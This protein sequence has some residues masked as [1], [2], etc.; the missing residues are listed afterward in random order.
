MR[1]SPRSSEDFT[2]GLH[3]AKWVNEYNRFLHG[4]D[5][6][7]P[8]LAATEAGESRYNLAAGAK[9]NERESAKN[10]VTKSFDHSETVAALFTAIPARSGAK[11]LA[12]QVKAN[13]NNPNNAVAE[14]ALF[15]YQKLGLK[16]TG[17]PA[18]AHWHDEILA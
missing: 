16:D 1:N 13:L 5:A 8:Q 14:A 18:Q 6:A 11:P 3:N 4:T 12:D 9:E 10:A 17:A 2:R 7:Q 15:A